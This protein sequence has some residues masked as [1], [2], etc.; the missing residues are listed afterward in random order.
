MMTVFVWL[1]YVSAGLQVQQTVPAASS[2]RVS[3]I[4][5]APIPSAVADAMLELAGVNADDIV[6]AIG[7]GDGRIPILA[8][9]KYGARAVGIETHRALVERSRQIA[10]QRGIESKVTFIESDL[11]TADI[12]EATVVTLD[13]SP[14]INS[15]LEQKLRRELRPGT[16]IVSHRFGIGFWRAQEIVRADDK[17]RLFMWIVP[18]PPARTPDIWFVPTPQ[19]VVN[20]M[21][22]LASVG[23]DDVV[24]D[25]GS[26]DGRIVVLAALEYGARS[27]GVE[28]D[29]ELVEASR[30]V[31][32][33]AG[34][35]DRARFIEGDLFTTDISQATVVT[36]F[37]SPGINARLES[38]LKQELKP[39]TR[40]V[41]HQFGI[42][43]WV[44]DAK[45]QATDGTDLF[46]W[47]IPPRKSPLP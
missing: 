32:R 26:G 29:P 37:L 44:P 9:E 18:K 35:T 17:N 14:T 40:V 39:G 45:V 31:A 6:Y 43:N 21:L 1:L 24:Y 13:L 8:A 22:R 3:E 16:R 12:A 47:T 34:V 11:L 28:L 27:V 36:L 20:A 23:P 2:P 4:D 10:R 19:S 33:S 7:S 38:K 25:L 15:R 41:S 46:L 30:Q 42:G 5:S